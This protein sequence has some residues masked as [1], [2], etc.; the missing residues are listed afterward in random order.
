MKDEQQRIAILT[1]TGWSDLSRAG[2]RGE[3][4]PVGAL[5]GT[6]P[7]GRKGRYAPNPVVSLKAMHEAERW[8][9]AQE[10]YECHRYVEFLRKVIYPA[11]PATVG[12]FRL[13][14]ATAAQRAESF[15]KTLNL[16]KS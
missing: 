15:L 11:N 7:L 6:D 16:W 5:R 12:S 10:I 3:D 2:R 9:E 8:M 13:I 4:G 1:A 14:N